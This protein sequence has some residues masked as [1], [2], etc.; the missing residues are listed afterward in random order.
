MNK[1]NNNNKKKRKRLL[2]KLGVEI[3]KWRR[4]FSGDSGCCGSRSTSR[5]RDHSQGKGVPPW[6]ARS[7]IVLE[8]IVLLCIRIASVN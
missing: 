6:V 2:V 4:R 7:H 1:N 3:C 5:A 8:V